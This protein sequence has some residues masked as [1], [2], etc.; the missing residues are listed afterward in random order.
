MLFPVI[1]RALQTQRQQGKNDSQAKK[2]KEHISNAVFRN[3]SE[4]TP[5]SL[6]GQVD[7]LLKIM[8]TSVTFASAKRKQAAQGL[9]SRGDN[10]D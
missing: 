4:E 7:D 6:Q 3:F 9:V 2:Q 10:S 8:N 1:R 5:E